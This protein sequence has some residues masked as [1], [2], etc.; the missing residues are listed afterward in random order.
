MRTPA[1]LFALAWMCAARL[2]GQDSTVTNHDSS[3]TYERCRVELS[4]KS[5]QLFAGPRHTPLPVETLL[6]SENSNVKAEYGS[7]RSD[8]KVAGALAVVAGVTTLVQLGLWDNACAAGNPTKEGQALAFSCLL[9]KGP[10]F[11]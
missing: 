6:T 3:C 11:V 4:T 1:L 2:S 9:P 8:Q 5:L 7:F 10:G